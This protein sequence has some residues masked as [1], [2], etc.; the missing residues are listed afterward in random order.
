LSL[1]VV[2]SHRLCPLVR[3]DLMWH[4]LAWIAQHVANSPSC[5]DVLLTTR[6]FRQLLPRLMEAARH[7]AATVCSIWLGNTTG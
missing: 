1:M 5:L 3:L 6:R 2:S 4:G 7:R